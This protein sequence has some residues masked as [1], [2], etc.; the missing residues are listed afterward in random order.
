[1][2]KNFALPRPHGVVPRKRLH[3]YLDDNHDK[4][5]II[6]QGQAAQGKS[7]F[8]ASYLSHCTDCSIW[9]NLGA[10]TSDHTTLFDFLIT[11][12][13]NNRETR[14]A[15]EKIMH[16]HPTLGAG[17]S[18]IR[19]VAIVQSV[20]SNISVPVNI[21]FDNLEFIQED[22]SSYEFIRKILENLPSCIRVFLISRTTPPF[23]MSRLKMETPFLLITND[24]LAFTFE[25][26]QYFFQKHH[27]ESFPLEQIEKI[28]AI[29]DGWPGG[30]VLISASLERNNQV[31][32]LPIHLSPEAS[33]FFSREIF[34][35]LPDQA[36][37]FLMKS[38]L[39]DEIDPE[40]A[41]RITSPDE[42]AK[43][44]KFLTKR[45]LFIQ[46]LTDT[47]RGYC[48][49]FN[50]LFQS[51]LHQVLREK[52]PLPE[53]RELNQ[54]AGRLFYDR[55]EYEQSIPYFTEAQDWTMAGDM[56]K[57][58]A[59]DMVIKGQYKTL[60]KW[61]NAL[62]ENMTGSDPWLMYYL[63]MTRR[64]KGG[65]RNIRDFLTALNLFREKKDIRG[66]MLSTAHLIEA[67]VFLR[68]S[69]AKTA[70]WIK[71]GEALL[72]QVQD[73]PIFNWARALL[74]QQIGFGYIAGEIDIQR[75]ISACKSAQLLARQIKNREIELNASIVKVFGY[76]RC[77]NFSRAEFLLDNLKT[78]TKES[79]HPEY[80][81]LK[82]LVKIDFFLKQ[83]AFDRAEEDIQMS[84]QD[85]EKFGLVFLYPAF[86]EL[87][88]MHRIYTGRYQ[89]AARHADHLA[90]ISILSGNHFYT[91]LAHYLKS[92]IFYH[93]EKY[94]KAET[95]SQHALSIFLEKKG[96]KTHLHTIWLVQGLILINKK[97]YEPAQK[98]LIKALDYFSRTSSDLAWTETH[99]ALGL[100][101][102]EQKKEKET[103]SHILTAFKK[104]LEK[105]FSRFVVMSP[106]DFSRL[107]LLAIC[108]KKENEP[109]KN[110]L[111]KI[112]AQFPS[113]ISSQLSSL[114][115]HPFSFHCHERRA[116]LKQI[117]KQTLPHVRIQTLG[118]FKVFI[119]H[120]P[121]PASLW[122]GNKPKLMLKSIICRSGAHVSKEMVIDDIWPGASERAGEKNFKINLHRLRKVMEPAV[123]KNTGYSFILLESGRITLDPELVSVDAYEFNDLASKGNVCLAREETDHAVK[124]YKKAE[125]LY[126][127]EFLS[128]DPYEE[129]ISIK[130]DQLKS[131]YIDILMALARLHEDMN[132]PHMSVSYLKKIITADPLNEEA[133]QNLMI[134][135]A[136]MGMK[137]AAENVYK[138]WCQTIRAELDVEPDEETVN[139]YEKIQKMRLPSVR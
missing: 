116:R 46:R 27:I 92:L 42:A 34:D 101:F 8:A 65:K 80:R 103:E 6:I 72:M 31:P 39:F 73:Q 131:L 64:I 132:E 11:A 22:S 56:V 76:V 106:V 55:G 60:N 47:S 84:E 32:E 111:W 113:H 119:D 59:T 70:Q 127:G 2:H 50:T 23:P 115:C 88:V 29:T 25:E 5:I 129:W 125:T 110:T 68:T 139:I 13:S 3:V 61:I 124:Y 91:G 85:V 20:F 24:D 112:A 45:N 96:E 133:R 63:T 26:T 37:N 105:N 107:L 30:I 57:K 69:P 121:I 41:A 122:E 74:W 123:N 82:S 99:G 83:G 137:K 52:T 79:V 48:Y 28:H 67:A 97:K 33:D 14:Q 62:P 109:F 104:A 108:F 12:L 95:A 128:E 66:T 38:S 77:G 15:T 44:L 98:I 21:V 75:G 135:Y 126:K 71:D 17:D 86:V 93:M 7:S 138:K 54:D 130:R 19:Q 35:L 51:F 36:K 10:Q 58:T 117:Y 78:L 4:R 1:M 94:E 102:W 136:D 81:A 134:V 120:Q 87:K 40:I 53:Y 43:I 9:L 114:L 118:E 90:D 18:L 89:S 100:L 49:R 16:S